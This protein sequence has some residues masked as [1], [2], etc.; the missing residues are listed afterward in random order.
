MPAV[1]SQYQIDLNFSGEEPVALPIHQKISNKL[2]SLRNK[3]DENEKLQSVVGDLSGLK[4]SDLETTKY[5]LIAIQRYI[6]G[7]IQAYPNQIRVFGPNFEVRKERKRKVE[8]TLALVGLW[9]EFRINVQDKTQAQRALKS[10]QGRTVQQI[11]KRAR[12]SEYTINKVYVG[13]EMTQDKF[14]QELQ[15]SGQRAHDDF[16]FDDPMLEA[17]ENDP[18]QLIEAFDKWPVRVV[19]KFLEKLAEAV[20]QKTESSTQ[21]ELLEKMT[22]IVSRKRD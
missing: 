2:Q 13:N 8:K 15:N 22:K 9:K 5:I 3:L 7:T 10:I 11:N 16:D 21:K 18:D 6:K 17:F 14:N 12:D 20:A 4:F 1:P 19:A